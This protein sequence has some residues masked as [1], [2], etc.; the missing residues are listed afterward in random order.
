MKVKIKVK[1]DLSNQSE[2]R[3]MLPHRNSRFIY[4]FIFFR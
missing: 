1:S 3:N 2:T 4:L